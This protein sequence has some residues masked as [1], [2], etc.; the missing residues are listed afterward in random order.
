MQFYLKER[1]ASEPGLKPVS[2]LY[3]EVLLH[4]T[5]NFKDLGCNLLVTYLTD[6][7]YVLLC[8]YGYIETNNYPPVDLSGNMLTLR[9]KDCRS[10]PG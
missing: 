5:K 9:P 10:K 1:I 3:A 2:T 6:H 7:V 8:V 4:H